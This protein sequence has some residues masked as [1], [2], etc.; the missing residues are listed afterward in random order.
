M[1][2]GIKIIILII[3]IIMIMIILII[4]TLKHVMN[5][6][7]LEGRSLWLYYKIEDSQFEIKAM[8]KST[9]KSTG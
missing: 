2:M 9:F 6:A 3:T 4:E 7:L 5:Y 8:K 1:M